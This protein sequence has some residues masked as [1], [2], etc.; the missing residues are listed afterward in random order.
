ML[1]KEEAPLNSDDDGMV[2]I[3]QSDGLADAVVV[4]VVVFC[5]TE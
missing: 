4:V 3:F 1:D 5:R 2:I